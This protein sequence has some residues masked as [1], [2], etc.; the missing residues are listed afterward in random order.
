M[1]PFKNPNQMGLVQMG[2]NLGSRKAGMAE[3]HLHSPKI[4]P[5]GQ[6]VTGKRM[7]QDMGGQFLDNAHLTGMGL[8]YL[9]ESLAGEGLSTS[10][11][12]D[13]FR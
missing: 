8:D 9:P 7:T 10:A 12:K 4:G 1:R 3:H 13:V 2:I 6:E 11:K 5:S